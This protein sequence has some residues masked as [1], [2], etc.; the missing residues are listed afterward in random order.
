MRIRKLFAVSALLLL[1]C[2]SASAKMR[3]VPI[4]AFGVSA[5]FTDSLVYFTDIQIIDSAWVDEKTNFLVKRSDYSNQ[6][7]NYFVGRGEKN[8]TCI[9]SFDTSEKKIKKKYDRMR[10][11][12]TFKKKKVRSN[13]D[14]RDLSSSD[15]RFS[16]VR[17]DVMDEAVEIDEKA[18][19]KME[20]ARMKQSEKAAKKREKDSQDKAPETEDGMPILPPRS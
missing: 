5:S 16:I 15:F 1:F 4:Y 7:R 8:R 6:L 20:K 13:F 10:R 11:K 12:Y 2:M 17:P 3:C 14:V 18:Q 19:K 9:F